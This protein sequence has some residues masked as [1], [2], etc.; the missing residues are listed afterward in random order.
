MD[1]RAASNSAA[2]AATKLEVSPFSRHSTE[3]LGDHG[4]GCEQRL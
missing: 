2:V 4:S 3:P 1:V